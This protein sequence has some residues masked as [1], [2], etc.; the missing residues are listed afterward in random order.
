MTVH[1]LG[2]TSN[3]RKLLRGLDWN[4][5]ELESSYNF[6]IARNH[7]QGMQNKAMGE[8]MPTWGLLCD[9]QSLRNS[10]HA[11]RVPD[12]WYDG[13]QY[14]GVES[15]MPLTWILKSAS[16]EWSLG[17]RGDGAGYSLWI[18]VDE[19]PPHWRF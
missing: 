18:D 19:M 2:L 3:T 17:P 14:R 4:G 5:V 10:T 15:H 16:S 11:G 1:E 8:M 12:V 9:G 7:G 6:Y 13:K